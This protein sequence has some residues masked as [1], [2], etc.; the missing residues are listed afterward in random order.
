MSAEFVAPVEHLSKDLGEVCDAVFGEELGERPRRLVPFVR[1]AV[2]R[3]A[4]AVLELLQRL[5][6]VE[7]LRFRKIARV[8][9]HDEPMGFGMI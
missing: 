3:V 2:D 8:F 5:D 6:L 9:F 4:V 1:A 7:G